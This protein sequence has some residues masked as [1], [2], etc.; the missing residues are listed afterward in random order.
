MGT[1]MCWCHI[2]DCCCVPL[3]YLWFGAW[4]SPS[5]GDVP[6]ALGHL[7]AKHGPHGLAGLKEGNSVLRGVS[8]SR[9]LPGS[10]Q[11]IVSTQTQVLTWDCS[12]SPQKSFLLLSTEIVCHSHG[13]AILVTSRQMVPEPGNMETYWLW[14]RLSAKAIIPNVQT[15][16]PRRNDETLPDLYPG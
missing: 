4:R 15:R 12:T 11:T 8:W 7:N 5:G 3:L 14:Q 1:H 2:P 13:Q 9:G 6:G 10:P 16:K